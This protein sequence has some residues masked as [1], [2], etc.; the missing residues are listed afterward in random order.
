MMDIRQIM[1]SLPHRYPFLLVDRVLSVE[2]YKQIKA[3]KNVTLN[4]PYFPGHFP[5][6]PIMPGVLQIEALA[7]TAGLLAIIS[8]GATNQNCYFLGIEKAKFRKPVVPGDQMIMDVTVVHQRGT[9]WKFKGECRVGDVMVS[10][11]EF[12]AMMSSKEI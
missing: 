5:E 9:I 4:E 10:E 11:A 8:M 1:N 3:L 12:S 7:Q 6:Q 2:N